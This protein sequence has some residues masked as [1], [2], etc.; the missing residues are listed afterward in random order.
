MNAWRVVDHEAR[1]LRPARKGPDGSTL[2]FYTSL[3]GVTP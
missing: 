3:T 2:E 1:D